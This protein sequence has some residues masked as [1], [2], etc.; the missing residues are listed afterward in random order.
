MV[1]GRA[2]ARR[3]AVNIARVSIGALYL[4]SRHA[5]SRPRK[6]VIG[7]RQQCVLTGKNNVPSTFC[8]SFIAFR[9]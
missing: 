3:S 8:S 9:K 1:S 2:A 6:N 5:G 7:A 4:G